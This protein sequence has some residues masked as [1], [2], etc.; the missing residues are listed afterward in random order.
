MS[1]RDDSRPQRPGEVGW[2][3]DESESELL[4][5]SFDSD[6]SPK[7]EGAPQTIRPGGTR[8]H[9]QSNRWIWQGLLILVVL[10]GTV[11]YLVYRLG[12]PVATAA[13][14]Q[15]DFGTQ[16][17][18]TASATKSV[19]ISNTG[20]RPLLVQAVRLAGPGA[21]DYEVTKSDC[22][23]QTLVTKADCSAT[24]RF[25]PR[26][27]GPRAAR[28]EIVGNAINSPLAL[29]L[30][31]IGI[32]PSIHLDQ[33]SLSFGVE[34]LGKR[35]R[36][37]AVELT[38]DG[39]ADLHIQRVEVAGEA[40]DDF[41]LATNR[42]SGRTLA[43]RQGCAMQVLFAPRAA[44]PRKGELR[45]VSDASGDSAIALAGD[46]RWSGP[47]L[48]LEPQTLE[49]GDQ[50]VGRTSRLQSLTITNRS[51]QSVDLD[52]PRIATSPS[53]Y[54]IAHQGCGGAALVPG[55]SCTVM[56]SFHPRAEGPA[57]A[58]IS[59]RP[60]GGT[61]ALVVGAHG[62]GVI[63][64]LT[65]SST[66]ERFGAVRV[67]RVAKKTIRV[68]SVGSGPVEIA[69][70]ALSGPGAA[71]F[72]VGTSSCTGKSLATG[73]ACSVE[74]EFH[75]EKEGNESATLDIKSPSLD[76]T[77][78]V[79]L[80]ATGVQPHFAIDRKI[81]E[82]GR[83]RR[84]TDAT[85]TLRIRD[86]GSGALSIVS[87]AITGATPSDFSLSGS[88]HGQI[89]AGAGCTLVV[90]FSP[91]AE[92]PRSARLAITHDAAAKPVDVALTGIGLPPPVPAISV[93][94]AHVD[95]GSITVGQR[96]SFVTLTVHNSG[97]GN[98][99]FRA[100]HLVG[101]DAAEFHAVSGTCDG[102]PFL[103]PDSDC[104]IG[105]RF[106]PSKPGSRRARLE[107]RNNSPT[108]AVF[109]NLRGQGEQ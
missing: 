6:A 88:C 2:R 14:S 105:V 20:S 75:P 49:F 33:R 38:N 77:P 41:P 64:R 34:D 31:G 79:S 35:S 45:V 106:L 24:V 68:T 99:I 27:T 90:H 23:N 108:P 8:H 37:Q 85:Q 32:A 46:G 89:A 67:G 15:F 30:A 44:G 57:E 52:V 109:V 72:R 104:T 87:T 76:E 16:R 66:K 54:S 93:S 11:S 95:F 43:P 59:I 55:K 84:T 12:A 71:P 42:C 19:S 51:D 73:S 3:A 103:A 5:L 82:F 1:Q 70:V 97:S 21:A 13:A 58:D 53:P 26:S 81:V 60:R 61:Q 100:V 22:E 98:L 47:A 18:G 36:A 10:G 50:I 28:L 92:G 107:I 9:R 74:V 62:T 56:V 102:L 48:T 4:D 40:G 86:T 91:G 94:P 63:P 69:A 96:S 29:P 78:S 39:T 80:T 7:E 101:S 17:V 25:R 83:V 65:L